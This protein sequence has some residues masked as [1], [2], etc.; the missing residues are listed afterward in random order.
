MTRYPHPRADLRLIDYL[1]ESVVPA[2]FFPPRKRTPF[3]ALLAAILDEALISLCGDGLPTE[4]RLSR[5]NSRDRYQADALSWFLSEEQ[6][7]GSFVYVCQHL[8]LDAGRVRERVLERVLGE[9]E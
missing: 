7:W 9:L 1:A 6:G 5:Q 4:G 8:G 3:Q 2:Q